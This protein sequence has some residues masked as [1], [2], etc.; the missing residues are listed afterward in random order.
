MLT[1]QQSRRKASRLISTVALTQE[2]LNNRGCLCV[3]LRLELHMDASNCMLINVI[4]IGCQSVC[5]A[6]LTHV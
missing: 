5:G 2:R 4:N 6:A 3:A 1:R